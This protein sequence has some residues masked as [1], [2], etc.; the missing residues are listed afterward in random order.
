MPWPRGA[1]CEMAVGSRRHVR[2]PLYRHVRDE[3]TRSSFAWATPASNRRRASARS[4]ASRSRR[5]PRAPGRSG[6]CPDPVPRGVRWKAPLRH[7]TRSRTPSSNVKSRSRLSHPALGPF[8]RAPRRA[9][10][11]AAADPR[12]ALRRLRAAAVAASVAG[13]S[14]E[15]RAFS[16]ALKDS[17]LRLPRSRSTFTPITR[18]GSSLHSSWFR[19]HRWSGTWP[20]RELERWPTTPPTPMCCRSFL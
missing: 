15:P 12:L 10:P 18:G 2:L 19:T 11:P 4:G 13:W 1:A 5:S 9:A 3:R 20:G 17:R 14:T 7:S 6:R 16:S 8:R